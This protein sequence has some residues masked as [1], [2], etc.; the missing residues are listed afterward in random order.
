[1]EIEVLKGMR[2]MLLQDHPKL[3]VEFHK[4][5]DR[6]VALDLLASLGDDAS[7]DPAA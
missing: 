1:M 3:L 2:R 6:R 5:V 7:A 4:G